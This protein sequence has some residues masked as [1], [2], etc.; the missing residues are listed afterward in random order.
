M[1]NKKILLDISLNIFSSIIPLGVLQLLILPAVARDM[2]SEKYGLAITIVSIFFVFSATFGNVL[3]NIRLVNNRFG[4][5]SYKSVY[6]LLGVANTIFVAFFSIVFSKSIN[7]ADIALNVF[8]GFLWYAKEYYL[9]TFRIKIDY[10]KVFICNI[11]TSLGYI[12][13]YYIFK[14]CGKWQS[15][16]L[17]ALIL[18]T[19]YIFIKSNLWKERAEITSDFND[20][21]RQ[22]IV[23]IMAVLLCQIPIYADK[24][25]AYPLLG[26]YNV[27][28]LYIGTMVGKIFT[29]GM[30]PISAVVL[31][32][33]SRYKEKN[34]RIFWKLFFICMVFATL[35]YFFCLFSSGY[36]IRIVYPDYVADVERIIPV[37]AG[38]VMINALTCIVNPFVMN[39]FSM[40]WQVLINLSYVFVYLAVG[41]FLVV[42]YGLYGLCLGALI[43]EI[44]KLLFE[45]CVC[46]Y[47]KEKSV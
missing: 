37:T 23:L 40:K 2:G 9:V 21:I 41:L 3:N 26:A 45:L 42:E 43:A 11:I 20:I 19:V 15:V 28:V 12:G 30:S 10:V 46:V 22:V 27:S 38:T 1:K 8:I 34:S 44:G 36:I 32:Y 35:G 16:Y 18:S 24:M 39:Y 25:I 13:G 4:W 6:L 29:M 33:L 14:A 7:I 5:K 47:G 31:S 17:G